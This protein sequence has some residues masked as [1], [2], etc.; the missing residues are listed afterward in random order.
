MVVEI[1]DWCQNVGEC[2]NPPGGAAGEVCHLWLPCLHCIQLGL[3]LSIENAWHLHSHAKY[4]RS[5]F[6]TTLLQRLSQTSTLQ[7]SSNIM[8]TLCVSWDVVIPMCCTLLYIMMYIVHV[9]S[10][11][12]YFMTMCYG[13]IYYHDKLFYTLLTSHCLTINAEDTVCWRTEY[14]IQWNFL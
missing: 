1:R 7:H 10:S 6:A 11:W 14:I 8:T 3:L 13:M 2:P 9:F 4:I 5:N 12:Y